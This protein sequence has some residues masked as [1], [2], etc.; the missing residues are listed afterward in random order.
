MARRMMVD[1]ASGKLA[2]M[3]NGSRDVLLNPGKNLSKLH[4]HS[5]LDYLMM[6]SQLYFD[7]LTFGGTPAVWDS[8]WIENK[9]G[10]GGYTQYYPRP[11]AGVRS[12]YL[13]EC[14]GNPN[15]PVVGW[16]TSDGPTIE[17]WWT[18]YDPQY[19]FMSGYYE[20]PR[21]QFQIGGAAPLAAFTNTKG[22]F[23]RNITFKMVGNSVYL[24]ERYFF[25]G[26]DLPTQSIRQIRMARFN[27]MSSSNPTSNKTL[28]I[29]PTRFIASRGKLDS[30]GR[31]LY[32]SYNPQY[33]LQYGQLLD[34]Q[35]GGVRAIAPGG[36]AIDFNGYDGGFYNGQ[37]VGIGF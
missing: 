22:N 36:A 10:K 8:V 17:C 29:T 32:R 3:A 1:G 16:Y 28:E 30:S 18:S 19:R 23:N 4:F 27:L 13:G 25:C 37:Q 2:I 26:M 14:P 20:P 15:D 5:D 12:Y 11:T 33:W 34:C 35:N 6:S 24:I 9:K 21:G 7:T 31:Y